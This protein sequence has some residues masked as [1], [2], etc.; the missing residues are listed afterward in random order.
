MLKAAEHGVT[1]FGQSG[2]SCKLVFCFL[3]NC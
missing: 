3:D 2:V 1:G